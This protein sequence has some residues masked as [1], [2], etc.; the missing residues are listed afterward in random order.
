[1]RQCAVVFC[2]YHKYVVE[3]AAPARTAPASP[4]T[5]L[6]PNPT[7]LIPR[8]ASRGRR[9]SGKNERSPSVIDVTEVEKESPSPPP[10]PPPPVAST[11]AATAAAAAPVGK[12]SRRRSR[13][14]AG[15]NA[16]V[17]VV[18]VGKERSN[19]FWNVFW[20]IPVRRGLFSSLLRFVLSCLVLP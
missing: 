3:T 14:G 4:R 2:F 5:Y 10:P 15:V 6:N 16:G 1:M 19:I 13:R 11:A 18:D 8:Q 12:P 17:G 20:A 7:Y 9:R